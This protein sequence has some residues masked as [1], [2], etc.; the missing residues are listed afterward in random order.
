MEEK[1]VARIPQS[2]N[3]LLHTILHSLHGAATDYAP[4]LE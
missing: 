2:L 3:E 1:K 4:L